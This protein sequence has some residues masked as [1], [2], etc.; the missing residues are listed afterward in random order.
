MKSVSNYLHDSTNSLV[1]EELFNLRLFYDLKKAATKRDYHLKIYTAEV[2]FEGYDIIIDDNQRI[3]RFQIKSRFDAKTSVWNIHR[4]MLLPRLINA[5][6]MGFDNGLCP[7][8][9]NGVI[10]IDI[11]VNSKD[12][13]DYSIDYFYTDYYIIKSI[14]TGLIPRKQQIRLNANKVIEQLILTKKLHSR[15][16]ISKSLFVKVK[17]ASCLLA[18]CGFDSVENKQLNYL[19]MKLFENNKIRIIDIE[20]N[21]NYQANKNAFLHELNELIE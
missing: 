19:V 9:D 7:E 3:G 8:N 20:T 11:K 13:D 21:S 14:A 18:I 12:M 5:E 10:L 15:I 1:R 2:D 6:L 16:K 17:N 4:G